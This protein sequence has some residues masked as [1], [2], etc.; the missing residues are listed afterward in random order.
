MTA[1]LPLDP[2]SAAPRFI[3]WKSPRWSWRRSIPFVLG[4]GDEPS[5][6]A[7]SITLTV[8]AFVEM[9]PALLIETPEPPGAP[10]KSGLGAIPGESDIHAPVLRLSLGRVVRSNG[11]RGAEALSR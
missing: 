10:V 2:A 6:G 9:Q 8:S 5:V 3:S 7:L 11:V 1:Q 4:D